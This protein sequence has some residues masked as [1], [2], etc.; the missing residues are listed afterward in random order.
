MDLVQDF[1][2]AFK[3][4]QQQPEKSMTDL[5]IVLKQHAQDIN[6]CETWRWDVMRA[7]VGDDLDYVKLVTTTQLTMS[8]EQQRKTLEEEPAILNLTAM[9]LHAH[10][11]K[12]HQ[13]VDVVSIQ[14]SVFG[15]ELFSKIEAQTIAFLDKLLTK[16]LTSENVHDMS[17]LDYANYL[18]KSYSVEYEQYYYWPHIKAIMDKAIASIS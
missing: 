16:M 14:K 6:D 3:L 11:G 15:D 12:Y 13:L 4:A 10:Y 8:Y 18:Y 2:A 1:Q 17:A 7:V 5:L 9:L